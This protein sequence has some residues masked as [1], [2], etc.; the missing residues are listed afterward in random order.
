MRRRTDSG[1]AAVEFALVAPLVFLL[2][3]GLL[4]FGLMQVWSAMA[5]HAAQ[6]AA[7]YAAIQCPFGGSTG[8]VITP[9]EATAGAQIDATGSVVVDGDGTV[10]VLTHTDATA[11]ASAAAEVPEPESFTTD[12]ANPHRCPDPAPNP[13]LPYPSQADV[14]KFLVDHAYKATGHPKKVTLD[15]AAP[16]TTP[17]TGDP[18]TVEVTYTVPGV[19]GLMRLIGFGENSG[20]VTRSATA[21]RE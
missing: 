17:Q 10:H 3:F 6:K 5:Q 20:T 8:P 19:S 13:Q 16:G 12:P 9:P 1:A 2:I 18:V 7:R 11:A 15:P 14:A 21:R 4:A